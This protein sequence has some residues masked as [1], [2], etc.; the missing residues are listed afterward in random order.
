MTYIDLNDLHINGFNKDFFKY[1]FYIILLYLIYLL[2]SYI[3]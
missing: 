2:I 1:C 3:F